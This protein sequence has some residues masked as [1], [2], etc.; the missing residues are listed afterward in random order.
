MFIKEEVIRMVKKRCGIIARKARREADKLVDLQTPY[1]GNDDE[2]FEAEEN[3]RK[4]IDDLEKECKK[5]R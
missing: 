2:V 3:L 1:S 5:K 4:H